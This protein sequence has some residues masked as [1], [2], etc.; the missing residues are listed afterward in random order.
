MAEFDIVVIGAGHNGLTLAAYLAKKGLSVAVLESRPVAGGGLCTEEP[1]LPGFLHNM[2]S[3]FHL[4]PDYAPAWSDLQIERFGMKYLHPSIPWS[5]PLSKGRS[6]LIH[7]R[8]STTEKSF[9]K[10]SRKDARAYAKIKTDIDR[11]F[12]KLMLATVYSVPREPNPEAE[13]LISKL[14]WFSPDWFR[15]TPFEVADEIFEDETVKTFILA[16]IWFAGWAPDY[17]NMGDLVPTFIGLCNHMYLP[18]GG[19]ARLAHTL[20]RIVAHFGGRVFVNAPVRRIL[21]DKEARAIGVA[22]DERRTSNPL[23]RGEVEIMARKAV[24]SATDVTTTFLEFLDGDCL[25]ADFR[26][27][28]E[29]FDY[30]G[31]ALFNVHFELD[32]APKYADRSVDLGWSQD[33]G[34]ENY[35]DLKDD[36]SALERGQLPSTPRYEAGVN[37]LFDKSY[38]PPG[39]HVAIAYREVPN[40]DKFSGGRDKLEAIKEEYADRVLERWAEYAPNMTK[41]NVIA[42]YVYSPFEYERKIVSMR[43]G[44]WSLGRMDYAQ[45]GTRRPLRGYSDYRTPVKQ[46]YMCSSSCHPG[47]SIFLAA[48]YNAANVILDDL[49]LSE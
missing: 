28:V 47:G 4:W 42:R 40:T 7:N 45:S 8:T 26:K 2:H 46:L 38:A 11:I 44:N 16:N 5:A 12:A 36:L 14:G 43:T 37:T 25:D 9:A 41:S 23:L 33:I 32:E 1:L 39:K 31:N 21:V 29:R 17:E 3:N 35:D 30:R 13:K 22:L 49:K 24:V 6:I 48:G 27:R 20:S 10:Y 15:M 18:S 34:Y 19:T